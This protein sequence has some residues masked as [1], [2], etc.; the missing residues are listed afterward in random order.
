[1]TSM[2]FNIM[3]QGFNECYLEQKNS[4][5]FHNLFLLKKKI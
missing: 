3:T 5:G 4:F 1:M 2:N